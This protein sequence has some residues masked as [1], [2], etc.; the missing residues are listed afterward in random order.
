MAKRTT[1]DY[2]RIASAGGGFIIDS[3]SQSAGDMIRI[4]TAAKQS[5]ASVTFT[6]TNT[7]SVSD[8]IRVGG[9]GAGF[10][11]FED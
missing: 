2:I 5:G 8:L 9:A 6:R 11:V 1:S 7:K 3:S 10:V 4:A